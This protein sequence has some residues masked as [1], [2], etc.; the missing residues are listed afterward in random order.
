M[1]QQRRGAAAALG[2]A[3][4]LAS[5]AAG[6][7]GCSDQAAG[8]QDRLSADPVY[9]AAD[10]L[11]GAGSSLARTTTRLEGGHNAVTVQGTGGFDYRRRLGRLTVVLPGQQPAGTSA[12]AP[13]TEVLAPGALYMKNRAQG[14]PPGAWVRVDTARLPDGELVTG[15]V[16]DPM[17]AAEVLRGARS[18]A[19]VDEQVLD[20]VQVRHYRGTA[21]IARAA[22]LSAGQDRSALQAEAG[23]LASR[24]VPF[25]VYLDGQ[26]RPREVREVFTFRTA[27]GLDRTVTATTELYGFGAPVQVRVP[28]PGEVYSGKI[29]SPQ[30]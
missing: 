7:T 3:V 18:V 27:Q 20:G 29:V 10:V 19:F 13:I 23:G 5:A 14:V 22:R 24:S 4:A 2:L 1:E 9:R 8:A 26:G 17:A 30:G 16:T 25:D 21:D 6:L 11:S 12:A 15:G 28:G